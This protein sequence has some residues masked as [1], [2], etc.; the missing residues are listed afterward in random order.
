MSYNSFSKIIW[1]QPHLASC[2]ALHNQL[3]KTASEERWSWSPRSPAPSSSA[4]QLVS[5]PA[6]DQDGHQPDD[7]DADDDQD[8]HQPDDDGDGGADVPARA[9]ALSLRDSERVPNCDAPHCAAGQ[10]G[11]LAPDQDDPHHD[12]GQV[13]LGRALASDAA[14]VRG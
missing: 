12:V 13:G 5:A 1:R 8:G 3:P 2:Q 11:R 6:S 9:S 4:R 10:R 7:D 14:L